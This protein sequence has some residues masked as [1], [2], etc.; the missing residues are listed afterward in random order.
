[1]RLFFTILLFISSASSICAKSWDM[2]WIECKEAGDNSQIWYRKQY[3]F[4]NIPAHA[5][6][7]IASTGKY[8]LYINER[9]V[10][11]DVLTSCVDSNKIGIYTYEVARFLKT[12][13]NTIAVWYSPEMGNK[14]YREDIAVRFYGQYP[15]DDLFSF[16]SDST[17]LCKESN[18]SIDDNGNEIIDG[19][20]YINYW[21]SDDCSFL[22]WQ[23]AS[24]THNQSQIE[25]SEIAPIHKSEHI[26][27]IYDYKLFIDQGDSIICDFGESFSG[28]V[29]LTLRNMKKGDI[30]DV[31]GLKYTCTGLMDEQ[32]CRR[33][34]KS[35]IEQILIT[36]PEDFGVDKIMKIEGIKIDSY[37]HYNYIH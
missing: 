26:S 7:S 19:P 28:W 35:N 8:I 33:F 30:I 24:C 9:N 37:I 21:K 13:R 25:Y 12:G 31:N 27:H 23:L 4:P 22:D 16:A 34:T 29:R 3:T 14:G 17:W 2:P 20:N 15:D 10:S 36:G 32:A 11:R 5:C 6:I 18:A 1:M